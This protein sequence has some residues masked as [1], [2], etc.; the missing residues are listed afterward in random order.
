MSARPEK[1]ARSAALATSVTQASGSSPQGNRLS[2]RTTFRPWEVRRSS[3][4]AGAGPRPASAATLAGGHR[5]HEVPALV[6]EPGDVLPVPL[7]LRGEDGCGHRHVARRVPAPAGGVRGVEDDRDRGQ[8]GLAR[9]R[10]PAEPTFGVGAER[11]DDGRQTA[12]QPRGD[13]RLQQREGVVGG[14]QVVRAAADDGAER[15]RGDDLSG[16][17]VRRRPGGLAGARRPDQDDQCWVGQR[18]DSGAG[19]GAGAGDRELGAGHGA[20]LGPGGRL[21]GRTRP[22]HVAGHGRG[23]GARPPDRLL[24]R[25][26]L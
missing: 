20:R 7:E 1:P 18:H 6:G 11:V 23:R 2:W 3:L 14:V 4:G 24:V 22:G 21:G 10:Q 17:V 12:T 25:L 15:V 5:V 16:A 13:D 9:P 8:P 26:A 19:S